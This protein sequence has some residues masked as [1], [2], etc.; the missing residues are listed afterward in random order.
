MTATAHKLLESIGTLSVADKNEL[1]QYLLR[2]MHDIGT[3]ELTDEA[4][5]EI[6]NAMYEEADKDPSK[7]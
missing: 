5:G 7:R 3:E 4:Y 2:Q 6:A 1:F